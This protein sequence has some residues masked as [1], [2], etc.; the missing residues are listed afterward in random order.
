M[1]Q[2]RA[3]RA[4]ALGLSRRGYA[5]AAGNKL[6]AVVPGDGIGPEVM[7]EAIKVLDA[8][9]EVG[10][11]GLSFVYEEGL[12][13][14]AAWD[15]HGCHLP[16]ETIDLCARADTILFGSVGGPVTAQDEPKWKDSEKNALLGLRKEF[17]LAVNVRPAKV[18]PLLAELSPLKPAI[19]NQGVDLVVI[20][21][22]VSGIYF[23]D[24]VTASDGDSAYDTMRYNKAE[25]ALPL[26][27]GF[28]AAMKRD[29][30][31]TV[32]DKANVLDT[33]RLWRTVAA[34]MAPRY[35]EVNVE[36][37]YIDNAC[38]QVIQNPS[39][40]DVV[41]TENMFGD[42]LSD[43][44]SVLPGSL[45]LMPSAS[46]GPDKMMFEPIGGT[47]FELTGLDKA[48]PIAQILSGALMLR[49]AFDAEPE[50][51]AVEAA[52]DK[53]LGRGLRTGDLAPAGTPGIVGCAEM[54]S[55]IA[56]A[57]R[58]GGL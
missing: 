5:T 20:R 52:V 48:N 55:A 39:K 57:V 29:K 32:V 37:M 38:M 18:Y 34:E 11:S 40:F 25:I 21:E 15:A 4:A 54:G 44:A 31:L 49:Y 14:G 45:G 43:C 22:L 28:K 35:P 9:C 6:I 1:L 47:A 17:Q 19:I 50:A 8:A 27:F 30:R 56:D 51:S 58:N 26:E 24:H 13:G 23:G 33:S 12:V 53:V 7:A 42:I 2:R 10:S 41:A 36:Y 3:L 16:Q 46:L